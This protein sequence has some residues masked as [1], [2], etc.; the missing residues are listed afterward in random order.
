MRL[1]DVTGLRDA[2]GRLLGDRVERKR[3]G[4]AA[5]ATVPDLERTAGDLA[6]VYQG[7]TL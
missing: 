7:I 1:G 5:R 2:L 3:L 4:I 6:A